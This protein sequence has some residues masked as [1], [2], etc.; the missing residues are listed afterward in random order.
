[1]RQGGSGA[2]DLPGGRSCRALGAQRTP[3][4]AQSHRVAR[5]LGSGQAAAHLDQADGR[6]QD[7]AVAPTAIS[8]FR[9]L[10]SP[11]G[12]R[13]PPPQHT[14]AAFNKQLARSSSTTPGAAFD[15]RASARRIGSSCGSRSHTRAAVFG[16][17]PAC[18]TNGLSARCHQRDRDQPG[19]HAP[20]SAFRGP[21]G[22]APRVRDA[23]RITLGRGVVDTAS[24]AGG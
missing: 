6:L 24:R 7:C 9:S 20:P 2:R 19:R 13:T 21:E 16:R 22:Y 4:P 14:A 10:R 5:P 18:P 11:P 17:R 15:A 8:N 23:R 12:D 3:T 1:M